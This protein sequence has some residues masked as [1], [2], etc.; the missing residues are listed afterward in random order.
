M[1]KYGQDKDN[2]SYL[3][4]KLNKFYE[5]QGLKVNLEK[6]EETEIKRERI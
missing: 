2:L 4:K 3:I 1:T 5:T 6:T